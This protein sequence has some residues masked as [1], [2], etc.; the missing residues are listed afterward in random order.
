MVLGLKNCLMQIAAKGSIDENDVFVLRQDI[1]SDQRIDT[2]EAGLFLEIDENV[3]KAIPVWESLFSEIMYDFCV[4]S[5][6]GYRKLSPNNLRFLLSKFVNSDGRIGKLNQIKILSKIAATIDSGAEDLNLAILRE[7]EKTIETGIGATKT[8]SA[9]NTINN[10]EIAILRQTLHNIGGDGGMTISKSELEYVQRIKDL[11]VQKEQADN[12]FAELYVKAVANHYRAHNFDAQNFGNNYSGR[13]FMESLKAGF[14]GK[15]R[16]Y[17][18]D[19]HS[20]TIIAQKEEFS[21]LEKAT[22]DN[23]INSDGQIDE[24]EKQAIEYLKTA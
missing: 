3:H 20:E 22:F 13:E 21:T 7:I 10:D 24:Y 11:I 8:E 6:D 12:G 19:Q 14:A 5:E 16:D 18:Q 15:I 4:Y 1:F 23:M 9:P 17:W 2:N